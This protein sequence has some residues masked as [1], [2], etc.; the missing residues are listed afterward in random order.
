MLACLKF[1]QIM[2]TIRKKPVTGIYP[3]KK[4][5]WKG[6]ENKNKLF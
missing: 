6:K 5:R 3:R 4:F 2:Y 1:P